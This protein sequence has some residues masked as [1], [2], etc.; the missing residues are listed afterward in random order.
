MNQ[1]LGQYGFPPL[2]GGDERDQS[3]T[4]S[5]PL[6]AVERVLADD[7]VEA[8]TE[9][10]GNGTSETKEGLEDGDDESLFFLS[11]PLYSDF[12]IVSHFL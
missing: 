4:N 8:E 7:M 10:V 9:Q 1:H 5:H 2:T 6:P 12:G 11:E 3:D